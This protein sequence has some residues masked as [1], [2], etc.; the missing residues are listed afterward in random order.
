MLHDTT[1]PYPDAP[2]TMAAS[3]ALEAHNSD[4]RPA[5]KARKRKAYEAS[6]SG[7][8]RRAG[9]HHL[10]SQKR[11]AESIASKSVQVTAPNSYSLL[12]K[13]YNG[14]SG[15]RTQSLKDEIDLLRNNPTFRLAVLK[16]FRAIPYTSVAYNAI[17][18]LN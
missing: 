14:A 18:R 7:N 11:L 2:P 6:P 10:A 12:P 13:S 15:S 17:M 16:A 5:R 9:Q 3:M 8:V 1:C 4:E